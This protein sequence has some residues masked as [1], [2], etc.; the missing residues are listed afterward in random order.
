[1]EPFPHLKF[2]QKI[3]GIPRLFGGGSVNDISESNRNN[4]QG[5]SG[6]LIRNTSQIRKDWVDSIANRKEGLA[7]LDE[8]IIPV[9]FKINPNLVDS[10]FDLQNFGIE[11]ISEENDGFII[12]ASL[13]ALKS[14]EEK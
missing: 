9:F 14:L 5:H 3:T 6:K 8:N 10:D 1:M 2:V 4:R 7:R 11:I 13:D 12:G